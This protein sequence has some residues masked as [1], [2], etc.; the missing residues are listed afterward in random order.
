M[1]ATVRVRAAYLDG[2]QRHAQILRVASTLF[3]ERGYDEVSTADVADGAGVVR[4]L[5]NHYFGTKRQLFVE[6]VTAMLA[7]PDDA[8]GEPPTD[9]ADREP[10]MR[11]AVE[12]WLHAAEAN[13]STW[14]ACVGA[15]GFG[16]DAE[17]ET[18]LRHARERIVDQLITIAW[19][20]PSEAPV[21]LRTLAHGYY[22]FAEA[23]TAEWL[24]IQPL[25]RT[26]VAEMLFRGLVAI[27][28][29]VLVDVAGEA[30]GGV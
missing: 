29:V 5:V 10:A 25:P 4:G 15:Q 8:F 21:E 27:V 14:L 19:G 9:E 18:V 16:R 1:A 6:V 22:G 2:E 11:A 24:L 12:L 17:V 13:R 28:E 26:V 23:I 3:A 20:P 30:G 7:V